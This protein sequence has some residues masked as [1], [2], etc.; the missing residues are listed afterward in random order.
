ML[1]ILYVLGLLALVVVGIIAVVLLHRVNRAG[2][3]EQRSDPADQTP[4]P[5]GRE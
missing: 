5:P 1:A 2:W 3:L 4:D